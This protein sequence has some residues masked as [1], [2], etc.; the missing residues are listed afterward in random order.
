M[1]ALEKDSN[2]E[3][4]KMIEQLEAFFEPITQQLEPIINPLIHQEK[5]EG[6]EGGDPAAAAKGKD[7]KKDD[8]KDKGKAPPAKGKG[9]AEAMLAAYES[10]LPLTSSGIE[11]L[12]LILDTKLESL[13]LE[14][15]KVFRDIPVISRDFNLH[16]Y[17]QRLK[18]LGHQADL[19]NNKGIAKDK[20]GYIVDPP[21]SLER[22]ATDLVKE[23]FGKMQNGLTWTGVLTNAEHSPSSGEW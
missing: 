18:A 12:V 3:I 1:E 23:E 17:V 4:T 14:S 8:K 7:A 22:E 21:K 10:N 9:G 13:P 15:L 5:G 19:H 6:E 16:M 11:S 20:L 2:I